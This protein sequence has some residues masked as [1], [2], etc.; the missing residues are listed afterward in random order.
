MSRSLVPR[1]PTNAYKWFKDWRHAPLPLQLSPMMT[2]FGFRLSWPTFSLHLRILR[3]ELR[4]VT[5]VRAEIQSPMSG[6]S[7]VQPT[8]SAGI[9]KL[10]L[11]LT[12][13][14]E[15]LAS[16]DV[17]AYFAHQSFKM[18]PSFM[19]YN[20]RSGSLVFLSLRLTMTT[21]WHAGSS[22]MV[23]RSRFNVH[24][25][26]SW[27]PRLNPTQHS[28]VNVSDGFEQLGG[29]TSPLCSS[30]KLSGGEWSR[31]LLTISLADW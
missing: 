12:W 22:I 26:L 11:P 15:L 31:Y 21:S 27:L 20:M 18:K 5:P 9:S 19:S 29:A 14:V 10:L 25:K 6:N 16:L 1:K 8:L 30:I 17:L 13:T 4:E 7:L 2:S 3:S 24:P 28:S 23:G